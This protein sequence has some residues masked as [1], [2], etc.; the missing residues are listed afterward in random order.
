MSDDQAP[1]LSIAAPALTEVSE[2]RQRWRWGGAAA[3]CTAGVLALVVLAGRPASR[4]LRSSADFMSLAVDESEDTEERHRKVKH[5]LGAEAD[6]FEDPED[7]HRTLGRHHSEEVDEPDET[8]EGH[9]TLEPHHGKEVDEPDEIEEGHRT[10]GRHHGEASDKP[11]EKEERHRKCASHGEN[12]WMSRC[13]E[14][15]EH[16][17]FMK[18]G[19]WA[20]CRHECTPGVQKSDP[21]EVQKPWTC[22]IVPMH[23]E[24]LPQPGMEQVQELRPLPGEN[25]HEKVPAEFNEYPTLFCFLIIRSKTYEL[26]LVREQNLLGAGIFQ[27]EGWSVL[28][29]VK[30]E[31]ALG[32]ETKILGNLSTEAGRN[33]HFANTD[34]FA[35]AF[36]MLR[37]EGEMMKRDFVVKVDPD[38]VFMPFVLK[39]EILTRTTTT[40]APNLYFQ[41]CRFQNKLWMFGAVEV[42]SKAALKSYF[43]GRDETCKKKLD[44]GQ[45]GEDTFLS[46]CLDLLGVES[47]QDFDL[48]ADGYC[49]EAPGACNTDQVAYH[50]FKDR[51]SWAAA[52]TPRRTRSG[53]SASSASRSEQPPARGP[54]PRRQFRDHSVGLGD[55]AEEG[56]LSS[57]SR[58][59]SRDH[60]VVEDNGVVASMWL[61][62]LA[63][64]GQGVLNVDGACALRRPLVQPGA[65]RAALSGLASLSRAPANSGVG[66]TCRPRHIGETEGSA[67][68]LAPVPRIARWPL[69]ETVALLA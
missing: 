30:A 14:N 17:C 26:S 5:N 20:G 24:V 9:R 28:S 41:N 37:A 38:A 34:I 7:G 11:D 46:R 25:R 66:E 29:D 19:M 69:L 67:N 32:V 23:G 53:G 22:Y 31:I 55:S 13:C 48:L 56:A 39:R 61:C 27:C 44:Y 64:L 58:R 33:T 15:P 36:D 8:K 62:A 63:R 43:E 60:E 45:L 42:L 40:L 35:R 52:S 1:L 2:H 12:C 16:T 10:S 18:N 4:P 59:A 50:P 49:D 54:V 21:I 57:I 47:V 6:E 68:V 65:D 51:D 3:V